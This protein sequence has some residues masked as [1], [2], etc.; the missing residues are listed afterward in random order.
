MNIED[1][2]SLEE[3][4]KRFLKKQSNGMLLSDNHINILNKYDIDY[5]KCSSIND[6]L[7][8]IDEVLNEGEYDEVDDLEWVSIDL[9]ERNYYQNTNK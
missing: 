8:Q 2:F 7:Y 4:E 1:D 5:L 9:A 6:L 3:S